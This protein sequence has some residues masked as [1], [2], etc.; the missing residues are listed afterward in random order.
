MKMDKKMLSG[1]MASICLALG[2]G[3]S[4][5]SYAEEAIAST[6]TVSIETHSSTAHDVKENKTSTEGKVNLNTATLDELMGLKGI[7]KAK[8]QAI[9]D[10]REQLGR[11]TTID[12]LEKVF[13]IG[14]KLVEQNRDFIVIN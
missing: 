11:F 2:L 6:P 4:P 12:E 9:I 13:G 10:Y 3:L 5:F 1:F 7:G 8:A 14:M